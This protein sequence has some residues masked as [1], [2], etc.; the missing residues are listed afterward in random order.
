MNFV[1]K[2]LCVW[3][4]LI[5]TVTSIQ[6]THQSHTFHLN[7]DGHDKINELIRNNVTK[8]NLQ[9]FWLGLALFNAAKNGNALLF[10]HFNQKIV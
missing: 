7:F 1:L 8:K 9:P 6:G 2:L 4:I 3:M 10:T 5:A